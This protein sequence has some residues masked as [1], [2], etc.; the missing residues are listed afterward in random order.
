MCSTTVMVGTSTSYQLI[1]C[2]SIVMEEGLEECERISNRGIVRKAYRSDDLNEND[3]LLIYRDQGASRSFFL[4]SIVFPAL[5]V[6]IGVIGYNTYTNDRRNWFPFVQRLVRDVEEVGVFAIFPGIA[7]VLV[8]ITL[9]RMHQ[10][11]IMRI[12]QNRK[13]ADE[14]MAIATKNVFNKHQINFNRDSAAA[15]YFAE[16]QKDLYRLLAHISIGNMQINFNRDSAAACYFAEEQKDLYRL[17]AHIFI[18]NMQIE[19]RRFLISDDHF[20]A[21]NYRT[22][23]LN[24]TSIPPRL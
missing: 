24:E 15:C 13:S 1:E 16:E 10:L 17:L 6:G 14:Y 22:Y 18:G 23:M 9:I 5:I 2:F 4:I 3:W 19:K 20:R 12:Y 11:R 21:N 8:I 7:M